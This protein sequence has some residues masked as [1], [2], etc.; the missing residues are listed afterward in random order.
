MDVEEEREGAAAATLLR[1]F[2]HRREGL[3]L[4]FQVGSNLYHV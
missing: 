3:L 4:A 1:D 2:R